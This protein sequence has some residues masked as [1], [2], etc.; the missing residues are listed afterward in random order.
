MRIEAS[1]NGSRFVAIRAKKRMGG[2]RLRSTLV[3]LTRDIARHKDDAS[4]TAGSEL[5]SNTGN[6][7]PRQRVRHQRHVIDTRRLDL[8]HDRRTD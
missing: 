3:P 4:H 6:V 5:G 7:D 8:P 1:H 2:L